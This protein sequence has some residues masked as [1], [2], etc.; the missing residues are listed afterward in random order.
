MI[1][2]RNISEVASCLLGR[3]GRGPIDYHGTLGWYKNFIATCLDPGDEPIFFDLS[4]DLAGQTVLAMRLRR[5]DPALLKGR[6]LASLTN[7]YSCW[8]A[9]HGLELMRDP[10]ATIQAWGSALRRWRERPHR[11]QFD[12]LDS[13]SPAFEALTSGLRRAGFWL[14]CYP[15]FGNWYLS[16]GDRDFASYWASRESVLRH[17]VERK[18]R[19]LRLQ[20]KVAI[21]VI[22]RYEA[23]ELA[24][25]LYQQVYAASWKTPEPYPRFI[26]GLIESGLCGH[27]L[28]VGVLKIDGTPVAAQIWILF[29][30]RA[31]I[32]KLAHVEAFKHWSVGSILTRHL[33][34]RAF[35]A[36]H[37]RE[38]DFGRGDDPYKRLWLP[39]R[40]QRWGI[41]AYDPG[42]AKG[43]GY[44]VRNFGP[45]GVRWI[46]RRWR[47]SPM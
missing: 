30:D 33:I 3:P 32:F 45:E 47:G 12:A 40:R 34:E 36:L 18:E 19:A 29:K 28:A 39:H 31:T 27:S 26:P 13:S 8:F 35:S 2:H 42:T 5:N 15:Q 46:F 1:M 23:A 22:T 17:T 6:T 24:I 25:A 9:P 14:D 37:V 20:H 16:V 4:D 10:A 21:D 11:V 43:L 7:Y 38:I 44:A 41:L